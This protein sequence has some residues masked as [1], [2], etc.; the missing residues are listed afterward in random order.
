MGLDHAPVTVR[1][2]LVLGVLAAPSLLALLLL[3]T[4]AAATGGTT[5]VFGPAKTV[6]AVTGV[7][8]ST[9]QETGDVNGDGYVDL[10]VT[11][12]AFPLAH[13]TFP[14]GVFLGDGRGGFR[15][16]SSLFS[17]DI[18]RTQHGRQIVVADFNGD[19][20]N[21]IFVADHGYDAPPFPGFP[22]TLALSTA[23]GRLANASQNLPV[24]SG[25]SH[26]AAA[27]DVDR[28]G[29][30]DIYVGNLCGGGAPPPI[31]LVNDGRGIFT[32]SV[33][34][35]P[36][37]QAGC[38]NRYTRALFV[39]VNADGASDLVLG[40]DN[41]TPSSAVL[42]NDGS[43][44]FHEV[45]NALP[46]KA[47]GPTGILIS[48]A[49]LDVNRDGRADLI[50]GFQRQD[51]SGR[52][53]QVLI[54]NGDGTFRDETATRLPTQSEGPSWPYAIRVADLNAD[55]RSDFGVALS[56]SANPEPPPLYIDDG[57]GIFRMSIARGTRP[58]FSLVDANRDGR[59]DVLAS[60]PGAGDGTDI[61]EVHELQV[62]LVEAQK[63]T[64]VRARQ[65][66]RAI[67]VTWKLSSATTSYE[68]WRATNQ[69]GRRL[70]GR[71]RATP[72]IDRRVRPKVVYRYWVR[73]LN[74]VGKSAFSDPATA[75]LRR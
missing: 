23:D 59:P 68:V 39:D 44:H 48:I 33:G 60:R 70:L 42:L 41:Q 38:T 36:P 46:S 35:L 63:P 61:P 1:P 28:D 5:P 31:L 58:L 56:L 24:E 55:G 9:E 26:S 19:R 65:V 69:S 54:G 40:A 47:F 12:L 13:R 25:F 37:A 51:F 49:T 32:R 64:S 3:V 62:Q 11:R 4:A 73:G 15:D 74:A 34:L 66:G 17:G 52:S 71:T 22:N 43:G 20:R 75:R 53:L 10:I 67:Q 30:I 7:G 6:A 14:I 29:D 27:A 18:P 50:A 2:A 45:P 16:G 57:T 8:A 21:D 72:Y